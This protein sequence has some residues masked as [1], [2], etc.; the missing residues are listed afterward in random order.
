MAINVAFTA[1]RRAMVL[2]V[3]V[4]LAAN[5]TEAAKTVTV[6]GVSAAS[7]GVWMATRRDH[8]AS[9]HEQWILGYLSGAAD[10][11]SGRVNPLERLDYYAVTAWMDNYCQAHPLD[12]MLKA[13]RSFIVAHPR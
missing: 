10:N 2:S 6:G 1:M 13:G 12:D 11:T 4:M 5:Q 3:L 9:G 8:S 7:C